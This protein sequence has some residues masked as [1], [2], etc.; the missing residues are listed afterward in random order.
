MLRRI[1]RAMVITVAALVLS[2]VMPANSGIVQGETSAS[3]LFISPPPGVALPLDQ[4]VEV[5]YHVVG[6]VS[7]LELASD[8][9]IAA[10]D[11]VQSGQEVTH[12]W[13]PGTGGPHCLTVRALGERGQVLL[14]VERHITGLPI[15]A[16]VRLDADT[17][18]PCPR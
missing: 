4:A 8:E 17:E 9:V 6:S 14:T 10:M 3:L 13:A 7:V 11:R 16:R 5:R 18:Q 15:G 2:F 12:V 1:F